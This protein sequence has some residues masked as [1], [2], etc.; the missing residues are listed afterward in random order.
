[1]SDAIDSGNAQYRMYLRAEL[2][3]AAMYREMSRIEK[4]QSRAEVF[5]RLAELELRHASRWAE[6]LG[7]DM[8]LFYDYVSS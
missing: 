2:K 5:E 1:M 3:A 4:D 6:K 7:L 8:S